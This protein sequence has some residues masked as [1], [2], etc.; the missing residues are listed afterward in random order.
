MRQRWHRRLWAAALSATAVLGIAACGGGP[1]GPPTLTWYINPDSG[2][3]EEIASRCTEAAGGRYH[4]RDQRAAAGV[5]RAAPAARPPARGQRLLDRHH[6]PRPAL[7]PGVRRGRL[8][9]PDAAATWPPGSARAWWRARCA[10]ATWQDQLVTVPFWANTQLLWYRKSLAAQSGLDMNQPVTWDQLIEAAQ[11]QGS[12]IAVQGKRS[13]SLTVWINALVE[14]AGGA[15][16]TDPSVT[17]P[18]EIQLGL[19]AGPGQAGRRGDPRRGRRQRGRAGAVHVRRGRERRLVRG[20]CRGVHGQLAVHLAAGHVRRRGRHARPPAC[21]PTTAGRST[22]RRWPGS[23][24]RRPTA[25]STSG[26]GAFSRY[27]D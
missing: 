12:Q 24:A 2:G 26:I 7:H 9:G 15:I 17:N 25:G 22:R 1:A 27:P 4:D 16:I 3:Q 18:E 11:R 21:R 19:N 10:G 23:P 14:S 8:P 20:R 5:V 6:E 13:E